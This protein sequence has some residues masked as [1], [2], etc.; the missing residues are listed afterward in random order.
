MSY[1]NCRPTTVPRDWA[2]RWYLMGGGFPGLRGPAGQGG[3]A[4]TTYSSSSR[5]S[6]VLFWP[7]Q[8]HVHITHTHTLK[9]GF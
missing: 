9:N 4:T 2:Q 1:K 8:T 6:C 5:G 7:P 3:W